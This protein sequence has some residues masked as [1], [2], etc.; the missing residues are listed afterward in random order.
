MAGRDADQGSGVGG[1]PARSGRG[2]AGIPGRCP[3]VDLADLEPE[4]VGQLHV[5]GGVGGI[6][7]QLEELLA[8]A[9]GLDVLVSE[10]QE[11]EAMLRGGMVSLFSYQLDAPATGSDATIAVRQALSGVE[12]IRCALEDISDGIRAAHGDYV[13]NEAVAAIQPVVGPPSPLWEGPWDWIPLTWPPSRD[14]MESL[15]GRLP[16]ALG[17]LLLGTPRKEAGLMLAAHVAAGRSLAD[18]RGLVRLIA[19]S[20][21]SALRPRPVTASAEKPER[22]S[23]DATPAGLLERARQLEGEPQ[24]AVEVIRVE[25]DGGPAYIVIIPGTRGGDAGGVD[26][27]DAAGIVDGLG[28]GSADTVRAIRD[29]LR[30][31]GAEKGSSVVAVGYS[32]GGIHA[33]NLARN[34]AFLDEF[35]LKYVLTAGSPVG[36]IEAPVSINSLHL[37]HRQDW[38]PGS[39]GM[40]GRDARNR[41]TVT[42]TD[43][44]ATPDGEDFGLGP[45]HSLEN[46]RDGAG[47]LPG[48]Q[49]PSVAE[50]LGVLGGVVGVGGLATA[51]KVRLAREPAPARKL[52]TRK[53]PSPG[54]QGL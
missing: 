11:T 22:I 16:V 43:P 7:F 32:Q 51:T 3:L 21:G 38:V 47:E 41:V 25:G 35:E 50:S 8:G 15:A 29:G 42:L 23:L 26:P 4:Q 30:E 20:P 14:A 34:N 36:A 48:S 1:Y 53:L 24:A 40:P 13:Y 17:L 19:E 44:V 46:Y 9:H 31:A 37:E 12:A 6:R 5:R 49:D 33:M 2:G 54:F 10:L 45:G 39:D 27:F 52:P 28:Y 18:V